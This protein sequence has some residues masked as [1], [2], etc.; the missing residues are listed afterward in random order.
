MSAYAQ[1]S[2]LDWKYKTQP[3]GTFCLAMEN[4]RCNW[5]RGKVVGGSSAINY[6]LYLRGN[7]RDYD[8][9]EAM[10]NTGWGYD[11]V[12]HYFKKS[13]D[14]TNSDLL[15]T[16]YHN[17]GGYLTV[18]EAKYHTPL[19]G[20]FLL[21]G[22]EMGY[23]NRDVNGEFQTGFMV[24]QGTTRN[25]ARCS[26]AKAFLRPIRHR[27]NL[28][29]ALKAHVTKVLI[30]KDK[31]AYG[32]EFERDGRI[33]HINAKKE[34]IVSAGSINSPQ[35]LMLSGIGPENHLREHGIPVIQD[36]KVGENLQDHVALG[37]LTFVIDQ[38]ISFRLE[39]VLGIKTVMDYVQ[40]GAGPLTSLGGVEGIAYVNT[41]YANASDDYPDIEFHFV[42]GST[43][44]DPNQFSKAHGI[45][46][47]F[48][49]E[50][51]GPIA[52]KDT[53]AVYPMLLRP[54]SRGVVK[55]QSNNPYDYPLIY[56]NYFDKEKDMKVLIEGAKI[57]VAWGYTKPFQELGSRFHGFP[58]CEPYGI[59]TDAYYECM[60]R[61]YSLTIYHPVGTCKMGPS[62][63]PDA[64]V[65]PEL[66]VYGITG[67]RVIDASIMPKIVSGNTN[68]PSIMIGEKGADIV[69][70]FWMKFENGQE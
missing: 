17:S 22:L 4:G 63:D 45:T 34:V 23:Q 58:R 9:W 30:D 42:S 35:L 68:A 50:T 61:H 19:T 5:P 14:N 70:D 43:N 39:R 60:N 13:E 20:A 24:A 8:D 36:L 59:H 65:D 62:S 29:I 37:G 54:Q 3:Q 41:K 26:T 66:R 31:V 16:G 10:G 18:G 49:N 48:Y 2:D 53:F 1:Q 51:F 56:A 46:W 11:N 67:L 21:G 52:N 47:D 12:L 25:G 40:V 7:R 6:M 57:A 15:K 38:P 69:K 27:K 55:L 44:S 32:V 33:Y 28:H 64:V